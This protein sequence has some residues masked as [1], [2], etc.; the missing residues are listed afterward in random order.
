MKLN[1]ILLAI[2]IMLIIYYWRMQVNKQGIDG[3]SLQNPQTPCPNGGEITN[4]DECRRIN[5]G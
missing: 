5:D 3:F 1:I 4:A 2:V